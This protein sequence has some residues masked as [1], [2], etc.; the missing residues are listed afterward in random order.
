MPLQKLQFRPGIN[1][2]GT[3]LANEG[4]WW[5]CDKIR[6]KSGQVEKIGGW[7]LDNGITSIGG[8][9]WG[10]IRSL[11]NWVDLTGNNYVG[12]GTNSKFYIQKGVGSAIYDVTPIRLVS[13]AGAATFA[14][15]NGSAVI[16]VTEFGN[17]AANGD[18]VSFT[19]AA[20][21]GGN[22]TAAVLNVA[23]G[24]KIT[25]LTSSTYTITASIAANASDVSNGGYYV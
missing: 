4:G 6:F 9:I 18:W 24:Y 13:A 7:T 16:T 22:I 17:G 2:E 5:Y 19:G 8:Y 12:I 1:R 25:F 3:T 23:G 11:W 15:T 20:S 14:A 21:L 10:V